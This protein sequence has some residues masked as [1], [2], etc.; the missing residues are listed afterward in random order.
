MTWL[1]SSLKYKQQKDSKSSGRWYSVQGS[2]SSKAKDLFLFNQIIFHNVSVIS[3]QYFLFFA[4]KYILRGFF[5]SVVVSQMNLRSVFTAEQQRILER[6]YE[7]GMTNQ[8]KACFQLI[9]QCAQEAKLDFSVVRVGPWNVLEQ[10]GSRSLCRDNTAL[11][12]SVM[13]A[14]VF[15]FVLFI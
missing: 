11:F 10:E 4:S 12:K 1:L 5:I 3:D 15:L 6:Y 2:L 14:D 8:S 9:L 7:N 13:K